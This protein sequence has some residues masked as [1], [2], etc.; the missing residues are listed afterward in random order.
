MSAATSRQ[1]CCDGRH[2]PV[3][4]DLRQ[5]LGQQLA[6][7]AARTS[8][9]RIAGIVAGL[10][11]RDLL[12]AKRAAA[13]RDQI[14]DLRQDQAVDDVPGSHVFQRFR[15]GWAGDSGG[16]RFFARVSVAHACSLRGCGFA[17]R[18]RGVN[19]FRA[20]L[21]NCRAGRPAGPICFGRGQ[22]PRLFSRPA[23]VYTTASGAFGSAIPRCYQSFR[24]HHLLADMSHPDHWNS[25]AS[26]FGGRSPRITRLKKRPTPAPPPRRAPAAKKAAPAAGN[27]DW[28]QLANQ[29]GLEPSPA[30][31][32]AGVERPAPRPSS[33]PVERRPQRESSAAPSRVAAS[34]A[35]ARF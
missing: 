14:E 7:R 2:G 35:D 6:G 17:R 29:L 22:R 10:A 3:V 24:T 20:R 12:D 26:E 31:P 18:L 16:G 27:T 33:P 19:R 5:D 13:G 1:S 15:R 34:R 32:E 21:K 25:L 23:K 8:I 9:R 30:P 4:G 28:S 11:D